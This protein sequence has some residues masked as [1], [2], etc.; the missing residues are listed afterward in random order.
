[1]TVLFCP[2]PP[3]S[4]T[5]GLRPAFS[6]SFYDFVAEDVKTILSESEA[7]AEEPTN[8]KPESEAEAEESTNH[9]PQNRTLCLAYS[10]ASDSDNLIF[11]GS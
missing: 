4:S 6:D 11:T 2:K 1:M 5:R 7:E 9:K 3:P 8:H 10:S